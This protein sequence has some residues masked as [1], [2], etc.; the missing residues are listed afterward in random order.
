MRVYKSL[1]QALE[2]TGISQETAYY[3][4]SGGLSDALI[5]ET[6][7][8]NF[9]IVCICT[10]GEIHLEVEG[11][12]LLI[13]PNQI[14][15]S[16]PSTVIGFTGIQEDLEMQILLFERNFIT[17][18]SSNPYFIESMDIFEADPYRLLKPA[19]EDFFRI[20]QIMSYLEALDQRN[21]KFKDPIIITA[22]VNLLLEI[23]ELVTKEQDGFEKTSQKNTYIEFMSLVYRHALN[24]KEVAFYANKLHLSPKHLLRIV[25]NASGS[26]PSQIINQTVLKSAYVLL[27]DTRVDIS[28][29]AYDTGFNS[30]SAFSRFFKRETG[31]SPSEYRA[32]LIII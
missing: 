23:A 26:T 5:E 29:I 15:V 12:K 11:G 21:G 32:K 13:E 24:H 27:A 30:V 17:K 22:I 7:R 2:L 18:N 6:F 20:K 1:K 16:A 8:A 19:E 10:A 31:I 4:H 9:Y 28:Q 14:F 25:K 3:I